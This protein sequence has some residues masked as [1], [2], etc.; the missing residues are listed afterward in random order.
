MTGAVCT[1]N[2]FP[3]VAGVISRPRIGAWRAD[4]RVSSDGAGLAGRVQIQLGPDLRLTGRAR[5]QGEFVDSTYARVVG[6]A[7]GLAGPFGPRGYRAVPLR[8]P[9][10]DILSAAGETLAASADPAAL[11]TPLDFWQARAS[12]CAEAL[13]ALLDA[14]KVAAWR[15]LADGT[16]WV[17]AEQWPATAQASGT[18]D[19]LELEPALGRAT[20]AIDAPVLAPGEVLAGRRISYVE[21]QVDGSRVR[22]HV[23]FE[24]AGATAGDRVKGPL[25]A[26]TRSLAAR[27]D[28][29]A[30]WPARV[31]QQNADGTLDLQPDDPRWSGLQKVPIDYG[32]P[33]VS[34]QIAPGSRV[35]LTF[36]AANPAAPRATVWESSSISSLTV[37]ASTKVVVSAP[38][39][40][41]GAGALQG[42]GLGAA[43]KAHLAALKA[44]ADA[45][46]LPTPVGPAGP[47]T[48]PSPSV[49]TVESSSVKV[50]S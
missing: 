2:G 32:V 43:L 31:V 39:V 50:T 4:L 8:V 41:L 13:A 44:W 28:Y 25:A 12:S 16:V 14:A 21:H 45:L 6:G 49:P 22:H 37:T 3:V 7:G 15:V 34:A 11:S 19:Q 27:M 36:A 1:A 35:L 10:V 38:A 17:G 5:R 26:F 20:L 18:W 42:A 30:A 23:W 47:P 33:G 29:A 46:V 24:D 9:L 48:V 40:E